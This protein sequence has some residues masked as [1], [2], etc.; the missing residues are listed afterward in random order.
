MA[1]SILAISRTAEG[2][3]PKLRNRMPVYRVIQEKGPEHQKTFTVEVCGRSSHLSARGRGPSK[4]AAEQEAT[5]AL[6]LKFTK[7]Q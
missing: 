6:Y 7:E 1:C 5:H 3:L 2:S 4:K